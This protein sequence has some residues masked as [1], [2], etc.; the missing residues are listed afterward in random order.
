MWLFHVLSKFHSIFS[1]KITVPILGENDKSEKG[2]TDQD[3]WVSIDFEIGAKSTP[4]LDPTLTT[5]N[6]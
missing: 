3:N 2:D 4:I 1:C 6:Q 5:T